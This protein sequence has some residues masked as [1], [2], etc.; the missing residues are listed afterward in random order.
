[1]GTLGGSRSALADAPNE[2]EE[3]DDADECSVDAECNDSGV[4]CGSSD[5][6]CQSQAESSGRELRCEAQR[7]QVW[8]EPGEDDNGSEDG[9]CAVRA[10]GRDRGASIALACFAV[11]AAGAGLR[12][13]RGR[14]RR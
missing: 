10:P 1:V 12:I 5:D 3:D 6:N 9:G 13:A 7:G 11:A 2:T 4:L 8:C 14:A